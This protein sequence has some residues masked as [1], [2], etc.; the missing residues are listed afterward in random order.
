MLVI[1]A[2]KKESSGVHQSAKMLWGGSE[3]P[4]P[5]HYISSA[6]CHL[7]C[8]DVW[9]YNVQSKSLTGHEDLF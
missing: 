8:N 2:G 4:L 1:F 9:A 7:F 6:K 5:Y 3:A